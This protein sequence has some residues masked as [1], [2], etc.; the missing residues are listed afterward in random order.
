MDPIIGKAVSPRLGRLL[1]GLHLLPETGPPPLGSPSSP[2]PPL[3]TKAVGHV[4][5]N[6]VERSLD[7][8]DLPLNNLP[9]YGG[10]LYEQRKWVMTPPPKKKIPTASSSK[11]LGLWH[12]ACG[13]APASTSCIPRR[14]C[15]PSSPA[16][17]EPATY[18]LYS[19]GC[20]RTLSGCE[21]KRCLRLC[22][23]SCRSS[24]S[25]IQTSR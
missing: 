8:I 5:T 7:S 24:A 21:R 16:A 17:E 25:R 11:S 15:R 9:Q 22:R 18:L 20:Q 10:K 2:A 6:V 4:P 1:S 23:R 13:P 14:R 12:V 3:P 19:A